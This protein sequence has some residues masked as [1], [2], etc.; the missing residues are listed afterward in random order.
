MTQSF[1]LFDLR[2][3]CKFCNLIVILSDENQNL[4]KHLNLVNLL[5]FKAELRASYAN[6]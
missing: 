3:K 1:Y 5:E 6:L 4:Y 2:R